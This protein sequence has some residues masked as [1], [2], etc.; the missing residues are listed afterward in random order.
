[1][2][3]DHWGEK[4]GFLVLDLFFSPNTKNMKSFSRWRP[5]QATCSLEGRANCVAKAGGEA[6]KGAPIN[7]ALGP[8]RTETLHNLHTAWV[9]FLC[10]TMQHCATLCNTM[11]HRLRLRPP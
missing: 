4:E 11:Q 5:E 10:H 2:F 8:A 9:A 6:S 1:M 7:V 3:V